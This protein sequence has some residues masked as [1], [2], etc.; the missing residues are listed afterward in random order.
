MVT[1]LVQFCSDKRID[2]ETM[3][4]VEREIGFLIAMARQIIDGR[5]R[6]PEAVAAGFTPEE[7]ESA[8]KEHGLFVEE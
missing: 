4:F 6:E 7:I 3:E 5:K 2:L 1:R 8:A